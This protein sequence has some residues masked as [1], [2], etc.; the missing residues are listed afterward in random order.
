MNKKLNEISNK[1]NKK[2]MQ[3]LIVTQH[4][5]YRSAKIYV[6][7]LFIISAI[8]PVA[9]NI[10]LIWINNITVISLISLF[11]I[12]LLIISEII[13]NKISYIKNIASSI[14]QKFD[15]E[16]FGFDNDFNV[17]DDLVQ[18]YLEKYKNKDWDRKK[19]WYVT[20]SNLNQN[21][22]I[23]Y[24]QKENIDWTESL[25]KKY[26]RVVWFLLAS[27]IILFIVNCI[28]VNDSIIHIISTM[29]NALPLL[30]YC[31]SS[32]IKIRQDHRQIES[33]KDYANKTEILLKNGKDIE[34]NLINL[35][36]MIFV[37]RENKYLIPDWFDKLNHKK[38]ELLEKRKIK[39][40]KK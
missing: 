36:W 40:K 27:M 9:L 31:Y 30:T 18:I 14:Q 28:V 4:Y 37:Y 29:I 24:C 6:L 3:R 16:V 19:D 34:I 13:R 17:N 1:Q 39:L 11:S 12:F 32:L 22:A 8:I 10:S 33:L 7:V 26:L 23:F 21:E 15:N 5:T 38:L 35:Q 20:N 2:E 25:S